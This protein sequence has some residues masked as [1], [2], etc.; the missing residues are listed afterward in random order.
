MF[1][2]TPLRSNVGNKRPPVLVK[3][4]HRHLERIAD[5]KKMNAFFFD[6]ELGCRDLDAMDGEREERKD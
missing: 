5:I 2:A 3:F 1:V 4:C 6:R